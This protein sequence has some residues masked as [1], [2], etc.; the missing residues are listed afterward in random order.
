MHAHCILLLVDW[1]RW[2]HVRLKWVVQGFACLGEMLF[3]VGFCTE[4]KSQKAQ[5]SVAGWLFESFSVVC[6]AALLIVWSVV[7]SWVMSHLILNCALQANGPC[8]D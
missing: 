1:I 6:A 7:L 2:A 3:E 5:Y 4:V 8:L